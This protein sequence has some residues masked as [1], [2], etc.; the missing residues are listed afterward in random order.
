[1]KNVK[2]HSYITVYTAGRNNYSR[3]RRSSAFRLNEL[4]SFGTVARAKLQNA[5]DIYIKKKKILINLRRLINWNTVVN[6]DF[7]LAAGF[8]NDRLSTNSYDLYESRC[9]PIRLRTVKSI[10]FV[11][12]WKKM[13]LTLLYIHESRF[14]HLVYFRLGRFKSGLVKSLVDFGRPRGV[15]M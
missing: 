6:F 15:H 8:N 12:S 11:Q 3:T 5:R 4:I 10:S 2:H 1:M 7:Y 9:R 13:L 14:R